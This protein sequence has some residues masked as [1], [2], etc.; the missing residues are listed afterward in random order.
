MFPQLN[1]YYSQLD[2]VYLT[3]N[4]IKFVFISVDNSMEFS[5]KIV[6]KYDPYMALID[7]YVK[8]E[9]VFLEGVLLRKLFSTE[10]SAKL[11]VRGISYKKW[12][13]I[14]IEDMSEKNYINPITNDNRTI[15]KDRG[16]YNN[17]DETATIM[18]IIDYLEKINLEINYKN[19]IK[20]LIYILDNLVE[21]KKI[22]LNIEYLLN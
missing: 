3:Q 19:V 7:F 15:Y 6:E 4:D 21:G 8:P 22:N 18:I 1:F 10:N 17:F 13:N 2:F 16:F 9:V 5:K 11:V 12:E 14:Y 20:I